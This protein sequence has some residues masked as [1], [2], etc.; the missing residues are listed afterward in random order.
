MIL[1]RNCPFCGEQSQIVVG[2][3]DYASYMR[4]TLLQVAFPNLTADEREQIHT[5]I[6]PPCWETL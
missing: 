3:N 2:E 5:G 6:C 1:K 4:G